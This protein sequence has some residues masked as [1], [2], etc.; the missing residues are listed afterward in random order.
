MISRHVT[1]VV[2][3]GLYGAFGA[4][5]LL[6]AWSVAPVPYSPEGG[7]FETM[8]GIHSR[9]FA[10]TFAHIEVMPPAFAQRLSAADV[11]NQLYARLPDLPLEND[12]VNDEMGEV[13][14]DN[15][16]LSRFIRYHLYVARR[17]PNYRLD[18]KITLADYL[19]VNDW[20]RD[21]E[22][23]GSS[24]L[25]LNPKDGDIDAIRSLNRTER[26]ALVEELV[27]FFEE[28]GDRIPSYGFGY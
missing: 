9:L 23:P 22:Y 7:E 21:E 27:S 16:L 19:G 15:T 1:P 6:L 3:R 20:M 25:T 18:W 11:A 14:P 17:S 10:H 24:D 8:G 5:G 4:L 2:R 13:D 12:Y 28:Q 26:D